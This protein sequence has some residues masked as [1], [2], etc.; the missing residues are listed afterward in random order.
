MSGGLVNA[1]HLRC[2]VLQD[3]ILCYFE[4]KMLYQYDLYEPLHHYEHCNVPMWL[5]LKIMI[6]MYFFMPYAPKE[7]F[8]QR[9]P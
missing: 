1:V 4:Q 7:S 5:Q 6:Y 8:G 2:A 9:T 3:V